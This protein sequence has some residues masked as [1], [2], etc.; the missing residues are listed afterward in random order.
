[1]DQFFVIARMG[2]THRSLAAIS[3][4]GSRGHGLARVCLRLMQIFSDPANRIALKQELTLAT[5]FFNDSTEESPFDGQTM[6]LGLSFITACLLTGVGYN[7]NYWPVRQSFCQVQQQ[8]YNAPQTAPLNNNE[9]TVLDIT[10][11]DNVSYCFLTSDKLQAREDFEI[12][13]PEPYTKPQTCS[14]YISRHMERN[15]IT[16]YDADN[17]DKVECEIINTFENIP[18]VTVRALQGTLTPSI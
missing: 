12:R 6:P 7:P 2:K 5:E 9:I 10:D 18:V 17:D 15:R 1:M 13:D 16:I 8:G 14:Q 4:D 11:L 3:L